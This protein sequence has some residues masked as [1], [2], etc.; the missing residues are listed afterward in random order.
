[1]RS[2]G[3]TAPARRHPVRV[4]HNLFFALQPSD[5][6]RQ[7][8][9]AAARSLKD[10]HP[11]AGRWVKPE[12]YHL[13]LRYL[14]AHAN[15]PEALVGSAINAGDLVRVSA[16]SFSLDTAGSF[17]NRSIPW[18]IGCSTMPQDLGVLWDAISA[19]LESLGLHATEDRTP[20]VTILR[21]AERLLPPTSME[22]I[23]W[24]VEEFVLIDSL[25]GPKASYTVLGRWR[26][27]T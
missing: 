18:W 26:L 7:R 12:R 15:L 24:P 11:S 10:A 9:D 23:E 17:A 27:A 8:I 13:T 3:S 22:P 6:V 4:T 14:G 19:C 1:M 5:E 25:L 20:H 21:D 2:T 16:F